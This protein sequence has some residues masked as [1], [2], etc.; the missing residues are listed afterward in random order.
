MDADRGHHGFGNGRCHPPIDQRDQRLAKAVELFIDGRQQAHEPIEHGQT[1]F[2]VVVDQIFGLDFGH[3]HRGWTLALARFA[4]KAE[5]HG[6]L[7]LRRVEFLVGDASG[8]RVAQRV[9]PPAGGVLFIAG[10]HKAGTHGPV[11]QLA[12]DAGTVAHLDRSV[13]TVLRAEVQRGRDGT[14]PVGLTETQ[15]FAHRP[16]RDDVAGVQSVLRIERALHLA[17]ETL[18]LDAVESLLKNGANVDVRSLE[19][20]VR[21]FTPLHWLAS[22]RTRVIVGESTRHDAHI[23]LHNSERENP[24]FVKEIEN[25]ELNPSV[26]VCDG[27]SSSYISREIST[28][29]DP[30]L[31][32]TRYDV[33]GNTEV[34]TYVTYIY[35][36]ETCDDCSETYCG[37]CAKSMYY[38]Y[39]QSDM[40]ITICQKC[41][42]ISLN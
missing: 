12:T 13:E 21:G 36:C 19:K 39:T 15:L 25:E 9:C 5:I 2:V 4:A 18:Q 22:G 26:A 10:G 6:R 3:I 35:N 7:H 30:P 28:I 1:V 42:V 33:N 8:Q 41:S 16:R 23:A 14:G 24:K 29:Y 34:S 11:F 37:V 31:L 17:V 40:D 20:D 27:C 38:G 32:S